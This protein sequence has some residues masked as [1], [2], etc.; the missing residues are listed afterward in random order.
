MSRVR[1]A[2]PQPPRPCLPMHVSGSMSVR[3]ATRSSRPWRGI[4]AC[5]ARMAPSSAHQSN[6]ARHVVLGAAPNNS[7]KPNLLRYTNNVAGKACHVVG[8]ATQVGLTQALGGTAESL[9]AFASSASRVGSCRAARARPSSA[10]VGLLGQLAGPSGYT[11]SAARL[12]HCGAIFGGMSPCRFRVKRRSA[13]AATVSAGGG[14]A[15][16]GAG[17]LRQSP[18]QHHLTNHS[19]RTR[20][21]GRLNSGV[22]ASEHP[23]PHSKDLRRYY[24]FGVALLGGNSWCQQVPALPRAR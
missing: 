23:Q 24:G 21:A 7:F 22:S 19:S 12:N 20:F 13:W 18:E 16:A 11:A 15:K 5:T 14:L 10:P 8:S 2:A 4:A 6:K 1:I 9:S 3:R 17:E